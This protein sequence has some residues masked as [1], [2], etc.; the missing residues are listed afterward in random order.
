MMSKSALAL[1]LELIADYIE[2]TSKD[3]KSA[4]K[5]IR[6]LSRKLK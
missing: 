5:Y 2:M 4:A 1:L 3:V 6:E